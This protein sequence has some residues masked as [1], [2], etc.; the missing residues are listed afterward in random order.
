MDLLAHS[1]YKNIELH[2]APLKTRPAIPAETVAQQLFGTGPTIMSDP[3]SKF[4]YY[5]YILCFLPENIKIS[6]LDL[7]ILIM[8]KSVS[9]KCFYVELFFQ[10]LLILTF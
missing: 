7:K 6:S 3:D 10:K 1:K 4:C 8:R 5:F 2:V 9:L